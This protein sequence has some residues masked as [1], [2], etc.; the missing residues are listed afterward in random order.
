[1]GK[2]AI[3]P[4]RVLIMPTEIMPTHL[5]TGARVTVRLMMVYLL[6]RV[7]SEKLQVCSRLGDEK[8]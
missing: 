5:K 6:I 8:A 7:R 3:E 4:R 2:G 1:M